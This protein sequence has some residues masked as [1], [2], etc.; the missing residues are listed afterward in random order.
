MGPF[1]SAMDPQAMAF[2]LQQFVKGTPL[3]DRE[4]QVVGLVLSGQTNAQIASKLSLSAHTVKN[5]IYHIFQKTGASN[6]WELMVQAME[7]A[8][9]TFPRS[10]D[11]SH[12]RVDGVYHHQ[13]T[14][15][16]SQL[17]VSP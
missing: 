13:R 14:I 4:Q 1:G 10:L 17:Y 7:V 2:C 15:P 16:R 3:S 6:R 8:Y 11:C 9:E 12:F 5:H